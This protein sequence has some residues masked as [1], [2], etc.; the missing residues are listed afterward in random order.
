M[1]I[2]RNAAAPRAGSHSAERAID[3]F[4]R[5]ERP[6]LDYTPEVAEATAPI[7]E[8]VRHIVPAIEW[9]V[10]APTIHAINRLKKERNAVVLA[11]NYMTPDIFHG[12]ADIVGDS[13]QLAIEATRTDADIIIQC[14][15]HFMAET[16]KI[17]SPEK[18]VLIPDMHAGCSLAESITAEDV[19]GLRQ[20]NPGV[21]IITYVNTSA[22]VKAECDICCTSSNALQVVE[23][24][25]A[26]RVFLIPDKYLAANVGNKTDVEVLV[27]DGACEVHERFTAEELRD[28]RRIDP[29][30]KIIAHPECPPEVV[31]EADFAGSTAHM[32]DWVKTEQP[33]KVMMITE[34]SMAD[35]VAS[36]TPDVEFVRP[37]NLCPHMKRI[38]LTKI[39]DSLVEMK[40]EVT[41]DPVVA[42]K[43]RVAVERMINLKS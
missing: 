42:E 16:S 25:G 19:R 20:R 39:L 8:K 17:L 35:N 3:R 32:I 27:W 37:C 13:L 23:S 15:V 43:A 40:E 24:F 2:A 31:A 29:G 14:G 28:Y 18:T 6:A 41:V 11:H 22:D 21:P 9:P 38:T 7:Y 1:T 33:K 10:L 5:I 34:C 26:D 36:E 30:V 12:V 4:G